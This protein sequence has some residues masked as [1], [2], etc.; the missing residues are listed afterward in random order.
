[1]NLFACPPWRLINGTTS[2]KKSFR[3]VT[4]SR[5]LARPANEVKS[6][7]SMNTIDTSASSPSSIAPSCSTRSAT[8]GST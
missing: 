5:A 8:S 2:P 4:V 6:Q 3:Y 1:M 7:M